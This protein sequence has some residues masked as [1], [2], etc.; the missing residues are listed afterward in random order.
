[1]LK[2]AGIQM[3]S[4]QDKEKNVEN[5]V[6]MIGVAAGKG[7]KIVC[8]QES[9][10]TRWFPYEINDR[11]FELAEDINGKTISALR[12]GAKESGTTVI[13]PFF[14]RNGQTYFNSAAAIDSDGE[15]LGL[16][17]KAHIPRIPL[18]E[19]KHYFSPGN[20]GFPVFDT[21]AAKIGIQ[22][23]WDNLFPEGARILALKGAQII[24]SPT[25]SS[26][27]TSQ[28]IWEKSIS[29]NAIVNGI[30]I[31]RVNRVGKEEKQ[32]FYGGSFCVN[33]EGDMVNNPSG[34]QEGVVICSVDVKMVDRAR[35][36]WTLLKD[37]RPE[38]Y[39]E[40]VS[41]EIS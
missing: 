7:A 38:M 30:Y 12:K 37:R 22:L 13:A 2:I 16:Y 39:K 41:R 9:F 3:N 5:A 24:F 32:E 14:E 26:S 1:M 17:R 31:L 19:E 8:L 20:L 15:I 27:T 21:G 18:Y 36:E 29:A 35:K 4:S 25:A 33:P 40:I 6:R 10:N 34:S 11:H 28:P 23:G